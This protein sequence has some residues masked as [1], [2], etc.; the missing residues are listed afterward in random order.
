MLNE[1]KITTENAFNIY[2]FGVKYNHESNND[3]RRFGFV[4]RALALKS[5][6][7]YIYFFEYYLVFAIYLSFHNFF[8]SYQ[9][10]EINSLDFALNFE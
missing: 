4:T 6:N 10:L 1:I 5:R 7:M 3:E 8:F 2:H 9:N